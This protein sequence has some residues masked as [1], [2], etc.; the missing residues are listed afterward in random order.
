VTYADVEKRRAYQRI[1]K[2]NKRA[3]QRAEQELDEAVK[4]NNVI[5]AQPQ[6][7]FNQ[8]VEAFE[9]ELRNLFNYSTIPALEARIT[10]LGRWYELLREQGE[11]SKRMTDF[12]VL[13]QHSDRL[14]K[15]EKDATGLETY[16]ARMSEGGSL[17]V[18]KDA[19]IAEGRSK[20]N[21][22]VTNPDAQERHIGYEQLRE[23][24]NIERKIEGNLDR[25]KAELAALSF[26]K[27]KD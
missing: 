22:M 21:G 18:E 23:Y 4:V 20:A 24:E 16:I 1:W 10:E 13:A 11:W 7:S 15:M 9:Q 27:L 8:R 14:H 5:D 26:K 19:R 25:A 2:R 17:R 6:E 12:A 3:N